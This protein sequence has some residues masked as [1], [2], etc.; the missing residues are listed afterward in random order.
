[1]STRSKRAIES[2]V[3]DARERFVATRRLSRLDL[4][5]DT[6][7]FQVFGLSGDF[8]AFLSDPYPMEATVVYGPDDFE[9]QTSGTIEDTI[10]AVLSELKSLEAKPAKDRH[11]I[12]SNAESA[13]SS[14]EEMSWVVT[15]RPP[16]PA[17]QADIDSVQKLFGDGAVV[18]TQ[19]CLTTYRV[20][21]YVPIKCALL[22]TRVCAAWG[23]KPDV[24][25]CVDIC[26]PVT[27]Y[28]MGVVEPS[29]LAQVRQEGFPEFGLEKQL[30]QILADFC[31]VCKSRAWESFDCV[32]E[33]V[34][35]DAPEKL[36]RRFELKKQELMLQALGDREL[37]FL[38]CLGRYL[39]LRMPTLNEYCAICDAPF[40]LP[41]MM[42]RAVCPRELCTYQFGEF[43]SKITSAEG[44]NNHAEVVDLL[45][46]MLVAAAKSSRRHMILDPYP[47]VYVGEQLQV[48]LHPNSKDFNKL[49]TYVRE[50]EGIRARIGNQFG[51]SW[52]AKTSSMSAE[53][54]ALLKW[55][56]ASNRSFLA[57]LQDS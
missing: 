49:E 46:C 23:L 53:A 18:L 20:R 27:G 55:T 35:E 21:L 48:V 15:D 52:S 43:G 26:L 51:A 41:P 8:T 28:A 17:L 45:V 14:D 11:H 29:M 3:D 50:L 39:Q 13:E 44:L 4:E 10:L 2:D 36:F 40:M 24:P 42:M 33:S 31:S 5:E 9:L 19:L 32:H 1:M 38:S 34:D 25:V 7:V 54:A 30:M 57:P 12:G 22:D 56:V 16:E 6:I 37:G 47:N